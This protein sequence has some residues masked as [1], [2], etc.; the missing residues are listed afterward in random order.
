M[1]AMAAFDSLPGSGH[2]AVALETAQEPQKGMVYSLCK[3]KMYPG[4]TRVGG[5]G[6]RFVQCDDDFMISAPHSLARLTVRKQIK[7]SL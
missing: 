7:A 2:S 5:C 4:A 3:V 6:S 1:N